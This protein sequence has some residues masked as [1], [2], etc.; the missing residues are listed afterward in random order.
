MRFLTCVLLATLAVSMAAGAKD[1]ADSG[2]ITLEQSSPHV[3]WGVPLKGGA[4]H[5]L[6]IAPRYTLRDVVEL[7]ERLELKYGVAPVWDSYHLG[8]EGSALP[9]ADPAQTLEDVREKLSRDYELIVLGNLDLSMF[10]GDVLDTLM[11]KVRQGTGL[12]MAH[13]QEHMPEAFQSFL[14]EGTQEDGTAGSDAITRGIGES[15]TAEWPASLSFVKASTIGKTGTGSLFGSLKSVPVPAF[16]IPTSEPVPASPTPDGEPVPVF[17]MGRVVQLDYAGG[18]P[19]SHCLAPSLTDPMHALPEYFDVYLSLV[20]KAARWAAKRDPVLWV[21]GIEESGPQGPS[22]EEIPPDLPADFVQQMR[23]AAV[24]PAFRSFAIRFNA[25]AS[26]TYRVQAQVREPSR[27]LRT[28]YPKLR[29]VRKGDASYLLEL[30][31]G[32]GHYWLDLWFFDKKG[33]EE[34]HSE[35]ITVAGWPE[36]SD[37]VYS[38]GYLLANDALTIS[39]NV[40]P[41]FHQP[42]PCLV[43]ARATDV[44]GRTVAENRQP[45]PPDGGP[46]QIGLGFADLIAGRVKVE[47]FAVDSANPTPSRWDLEHAAYTQVYLPVRAPRPPHEF[48]FGIEGSF[49]EEYNVRFYTRLLAQM[50]V[51]AVHTAGTDEARTFLTDLDVSLIPDLTRY[52]PEAVVDGVVRKP[53]L[54][55]PEFRAAEQTKLREKASTFWAVGT[56]VYFLGKDNCMAIGQADTCQCPL[57]LRG[58]REDLRKDYATID[59]LNR[60]WGSHFLEWEGVTPGTREDALHSGHAAPWI[61]FRRYMDTV[62][63][64]M[65]A[66]GS[67]TVHGVDPDARAGFRA[68][69]GTRAALGYDW[70]ALATQLDALAIPYDR[71]LAERLR[72]YS[73]PSS[74]RALCVGDDACPDT[75][76]ARWLPWYAAS[77]GFESVWLA[78]PYAGSEMEAALPALLPDGRATDWFKAMSGEMR[79]LKAGL[80]TLLLN[81]T[82]EKA[83]IAMYDNRASECLNEIDK[84]LADDAREAANAWTGLLDR[85][86]YMYDFVS[87]TQA[88]QGKLNAYALLILPQIRALSDDEIAAIRAFH[89]QGGRIIAD[90]MPGRFDAHGVAR[91]APPLDAVFGV[92]SKTASEESTARAAAIRV[93]LDKS[94]VSG[95]LDRVVPDTSI[96]SDTGHAFGDAQGA[97]VWI[98]SGDGPGLAVLLNHALPKVSDGSALDTLMKAL[99]DKTGV[100]PAAGVEAFDGARIVS[101]FGKG[102]LYTFL[103]NPAMARKE[104]DVELRLD[105]DQHLYDARAGKRLKHARKAKISI[106]RG[107]ARVIAALPYEVTGLVVTAP[108]RLRVGRDRRLLLRFSVKTRGEA[109]GTHLVHVSLD[110]GPGHPVACYERNVSCPQ[111]EGQTYLPLACDEPPGLYTVRARDVLTGVEGEALVRLD[112]A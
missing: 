59:F 34:W 103:G 54:S 88:R 8:I 12:L 47:L 36:M 25:P 13:C 86:G 74:Y 101:H 70:P 27:G 93:P 99:L 75:T 72:S 111:G 112:P 109:A 53:C 76:T 87:E 11:A 58:F 91:R 44:W 61:D 35:P 24:R 102:D 69:R 7:A 46:V 97:P 40:R 23:D 20:A 21:A 50:G 73:P 79:E 3:A 66:A 4:I 17:P 100:V 33:V 41:D 56:S 10:P 67:A 9:G 107:G 94:E 37:V 65:H 22:E 92:R 49:P 90:G 82:R 18:R 31:V 89:D 15:T 16:P 83:P 55:D 95:V 14:S 106:G 43:Y 64:S 57:C 48:S 96:E 78:T 77:H 39:L 84:T 32:P 42:R 60:E 98:A 26:K 85:L 63:T 104:Q 108:E 110:R 30:P 62:F 81:A 29:P 52:V 45:V 19:Y 38:K 68:A 1:R 80:G 51:D 28:M 71:P 5:A 6:F 2:A 105:K